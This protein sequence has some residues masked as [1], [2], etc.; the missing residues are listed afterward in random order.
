MTSVTELGKTWHMVAKRGK[1]WHRT[2]SQWPPE[3]ISS[4]WPREAPPPHKSI[5]KVAS[6]SH[7]P[8]A[9]PGKPRQ[10]ANLY[11]K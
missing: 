5:R 4:K 9:G 1:A 2:A 8:A 7:F 3:A 10:R 6:R 11:E